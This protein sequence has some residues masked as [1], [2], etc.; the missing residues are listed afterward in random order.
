M[1][2]TDDGVRQGTREL[3]GRDQLMALID[4]TSSVIYMRNADGRYML[5][6]R[7]Y[8]RLFGL[9][10]ED[11]VGLTDHDLFPPATADAF[12][13]N[14]LQALAGGVPVQM[15]ERVPGDEGERIYLTVKFPLINGDGTPYAVAGISTDITERSRAEAALRDSEERFRLLAEHAQDIIFRYRL[16]PEP[17]MEYLSRAVEQITGFTAEDFYA[18]P[19]LIENRIEPEDRPVFERSWRM[20]RSGTTS[21][22]LRRRDGEVVW[23]EQRAGAVTAPGGALVAVEGILRDVT[24][25]MAAERERAELERQLRQ[26]ERLD[27]LGQLAGGIAHDFN[28]ILA[29]ISGY[30]DMMIDELGDE[31]PSKPDANGIK[32]AAARGAALTRQLLLFSR[33]E[34]S[35][36]EL[37]DL[38]A[39]ASD[40][41]RLLGRTLGEDIELGTELVADLPPVVMDRSKLEQVVM[42]AVLN[43]RAAMPA[44]GR[45]TIST[46]REHGGAG[47]DQVCL[48]VT[49][50]GCG[51]TPEVLARAFEPFFTTKG[52]GSGTGLG[53]AT[54]YGVVTDAGGT[55][56]LESEP[57]RGTTLRVRLPA[58]TED[59]AGVTPAAPAAEDAAGD[60]RRILVVE[61]EEMVRDIVCRLLVKAGYQV[62]AAPHP[63]EA[64]RMCRDEA[65]AF[66]VLLSDVIMPGMSGTQLAAELRR[67]RPGLPVLFMSGYTSGPAPGGQELPTDAPLIRKPFERQTLLDEVHR[68]VTERV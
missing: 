36:S 64:L 37:L 6:N 31:H 61:D 4:H 2:G 59:A 42:N 32:Q 24:E 27:S 45:L 9:R 44:G 34:P 39:V 65:L 5:V 58:G 15:E 3:P 40:M 1:S 33:S 62:F 60:G 14:D 17:A 52:R 48:A 57:G 41:L 50:T 28:N 51:M 12:R 26:S 55:I 43:A 38:N 8:E 21:F 13:D 66:D 63:A 67:D 16:A 25:R 35:R 46:G 22:R 23:I 56:T 29:V 53:L 49:D 19:E 11:I 7:E 47:D 10:R 68:L 30:A 18:D 54:A 20:P